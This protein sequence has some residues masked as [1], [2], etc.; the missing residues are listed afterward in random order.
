MTLLL[1]LAL[2]ICDLLTTLVFLHR[3]VTEAN[4]LIRAAFRMAANPAVGLTAIKLA[5]CGLALYSWR[6]ERMRLLRLANVL[7]GLCVCWNLVAI[8]VS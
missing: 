8:A 6:T 3:G 2:Q 4:P 7:F 5:G 1:F